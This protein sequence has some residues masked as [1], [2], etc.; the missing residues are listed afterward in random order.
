MENKKQE[1]GVA[2]YHLKNKFAFGCISGPE[3]TE[4]K[5]DKKQVSAIY[6]FLQKGTFI[7][8]FNI[9]DFE[10]YYTIADLNCLGLTRQAISSEERKSLE[11]ARRHRVDEL[12]EM[13]KDVVSKQIQ[14]E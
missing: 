13:H 9:V 12:V 5:F 1:M 8:M 11:D 4:F 10:D 3:L 14:P 2:L 6:D 7:G